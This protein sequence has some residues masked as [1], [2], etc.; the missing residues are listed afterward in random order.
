MIVESSK[1]INFLI[2]QEQKTLM[3]AIFNR[4]ELQAILLII[5][6][7]RI[8]SVKFIIKWEI[9][10]NKT[11]I[12]NKE[13]NLGNQILKI[14]IIWVLFS[15]KN[16]SITFIANYHD[17]SIDLSISKEKKTFSEEKHRMNLNVSKVNW[18][19]WKSKFASKKKS[20]VQLFLLFQKTWKMRHLI[21]FNLPNATVPEKIRSKWTWIKS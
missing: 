3:F 12:R 16:M 5:R 7:Y 17:L 21:F 2:S 15:C 18:I 19:K 1:Q 6:R 8:K 14:A 13:E 11:L 20:L 4:T 10:T 9:L